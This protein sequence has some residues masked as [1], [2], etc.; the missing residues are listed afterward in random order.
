MASEMDTAMQMANTTVD[1]LH[2]VLAALVEALATKAKN[3]EDRSVIRAF[4]RHISAG[5]NLLAIPVDR[6]VCKEFEEELKARDV[7]AYKVANA[8]QVGVFNYIFRDSD[9]HVMQTIVLKMRE[10]G[11]DIISSSRI[12]YDELSERSDG[13]LHLGVYDQ[14]QAARTRLALD[15]YGVP[16]AYTEYPDR[17]EIAIASRDYEKLKDTPGIDVS[18]MWSAK[19]KTTMADVR[20]IIRAGREEKEKEKERK[21]DKEPKTRGGRAKE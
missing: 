3:P 19:A 9:E 12:E 16:Y 1:G 13:E 14:K 5:G 2:R 4:Q 8:N 18:A 20:E 10:N 7:K 15:S 11:T 21:N 17:I 6:D